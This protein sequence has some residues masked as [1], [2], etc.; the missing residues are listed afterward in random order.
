MLVG[1]FVSNSYIKTQYELLNIL[2]NYGVDKRSIY[3]DITNN[4]VV[5]KNYFF[6]MIDELQVNDTV[7]II[8]ILNICDN[9][10]ELL[11]IINLISNKGSSLKSIKNPWLDT[12]KNNEY[13]K[14]ILN[15]LYNLNEL[16]SSLINNKISKNQSYI[17]TNIAKVGRPLERS[18]KTD[19]I[20]T[21]YK[22]N[23]KITDIARKTGL[24]RTT[25]YK[26]LYD[27]GLKKEKFTKN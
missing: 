5:N 15:I 10:S 16:G 23:Y 17:E 6:K 26:V 27:F 8:D 2:I 3:Y 13:T 1:Y 22:H 20:L 25:I 19:L 18:K 24:S 7:I 4:Y 9:I 21:L 14:Y 11:R 12:S